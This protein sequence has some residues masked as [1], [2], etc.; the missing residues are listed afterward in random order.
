MTSVETMLGTATIT[1]SS[2]TFHR[3]LG[4]YSLSLTVY[5]SNGHPGSTG[6]GFRPQL[7]RCLLLAATAGETPGVIE[8]LRFGLGSSTQLAEEMMKFIRFALAVA[9]LVTL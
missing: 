8:H 5:P 3:G 2:A 7:R 4:K 9:L 1:D 6:I